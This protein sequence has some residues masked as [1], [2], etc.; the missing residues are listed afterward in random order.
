MRC[1]VCAGTGWIEGP[2]DDL[3]HASGRWCRYCS[4]SGQ[5][6]VDAGYTERD[7][8]AELARGDAR[9]VV[10]AKLAKAAGAA[11]AAVMADGSI[12]YAGCCITGEDA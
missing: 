5:I 6:T 8:R 11:E 12:A 3:G 4:G 10:M 1:P 7:A 9:E 2:I